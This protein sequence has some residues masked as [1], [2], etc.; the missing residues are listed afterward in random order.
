MLVL[1]PLPQPSFGLLMIGGA[2]AALGM[3]GLF[4]LFA[5]ARLSTSQQ[6]HL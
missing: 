2:V 6:A 4:V 3:A 1:R 5:G